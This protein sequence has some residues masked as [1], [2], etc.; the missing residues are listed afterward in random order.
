M[1]TCKNLSTSTTV[2]LLPRRRNAS[3][4]SP[5]T[6]STPSSKPFDGDFPSASSPV[7]ALIWKTTVSTRPC[8]KCQLTC[9][10]DLYTRTLSAKRCVMS[11]TCGVSPS[12]TD[13]VTKIF[14]GTCRAPTEAAQP[15]ER[16]R[17]Q[18]I[19]PS[20]ELIAYTTPRFVATIM[21]LRNPNS[22]RTRAEVVSLLAAAEVEA[23]S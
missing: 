14:K 12:P 17:R 23:D 19:A 7:S 16:M 10:L 6:T 11:A 18:T 5:L 13:R 22:S 2:L 21:T 1:L 9:R 3:S 20:P 8:P 15:N 4:N